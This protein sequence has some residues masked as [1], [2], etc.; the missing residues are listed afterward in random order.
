MNMV[1]TL[2]LKF[3]RVLKDSVCCPKMPKYKFLIEKFYKRDYNYENV[4]FWHLH[5]EFL[6]LLTES[7][8]VNLFFRR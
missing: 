8:S 5:F 3:L 7:F 4:E 6:R 2:T 1:F